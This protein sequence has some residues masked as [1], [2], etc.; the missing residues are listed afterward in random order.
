MSPRAAESAIIAI[1]KP[2]DNACVTTQGQIRPVRWYN[3]PKTQPK[4]INGIQLTP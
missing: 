2:L 3:Q 4:T 1:T